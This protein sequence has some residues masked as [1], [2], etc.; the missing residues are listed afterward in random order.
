ML[1]LLKYEFRKMRTNLLALLVGLAALE[2]G[3]I[4][5][6]VM[7]RAG[8]MTVCLTLISILTFAAFV[9]LILAGIASYSLELRDKSGYLIFMTP[10][11]PLGIV[12]SKLAFI[13]LASLT[14]MAL[15]GAAAYF[16]FRYLI[17]K[18]NLDPQT[19]DQLNMMLRFGLK[20]NATV[21][22]ILRMVAFGALTVLLEVLVTMC[23]AYL[24]ITLAATLL[25][26]KKGFIRG[27]ISFSLFIALSWGANWL[28]TKLMSNYW[29][30][31][32]AS[33]E[34]QLTHT[35]GISVLLNAAFCALFAGVS[36]WLLDRKVNL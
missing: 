34:S 18:L 3:F 8:V 5:G 35:V 30:D 28:T 6:V 10:V 19:L 13:A 7:E 31:V 12:L 9:Y 14:A 16:D 22:Q 17:G 36:A 2:A 11:K 23:T 33:L 21:Q 32:A 29:N 1:K 26:N 24:S 15:F 20:T 27:L 25:Q 4:A